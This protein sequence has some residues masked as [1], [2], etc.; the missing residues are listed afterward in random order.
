MEKKRWIVVVG[1]L[2]VQ[3]CLGA[4]YA[5]GAFTKALQDPAGPFAFS[6]TQAQAIFS[7]ALAAFAFTMIFAGRWQD[8]AGPRKV[9]L[10][11]GAVLGLGYLLAG[12]VGGTSFWAL[13]ATVGILGGIGVGLAY[14]CPIAS[15]MKW[16]PD[17][18]GFVV[19]LSVAGFGAGAF[20][21]VKLAGP[22]ANL[23]AAQGVNGT[24][25]V[26][27]IIFLA[28]V[29]LGALLLSNPP[30]GWKPANWT[31][32][33]AAASTGAAEDFTQGE[34][35]RTTSFWL[36][37]LAY[38]CAAGAGLMVIG[39][40]K[41]YGELECS[42]S[43]AVAGSALGLLALF[44]GLGRIVW[45]TISQKLGARRAIALNG[46]LQALMLFAVYQLGRS[47][48]AVTIAACWVGFNFG[49]NL[50]LFPLVTAESFGTKYLGANYGAMFTAYGVGGIIMPLLA[51]RVYDV[52]GSHFW[53]F[54][55]AGIAC[56]IAML[57]ALVVRAPHHAASRAGNPAYEAS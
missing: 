25:T 36:L 34:T 9:A 38:V 42:L 43:A 45:G 15:C 37:W 48:L 4:L 27:G 52:L 1:A 33:A 2:L 23:I 44:N 28:G 31:P 32:K 3:L 22:W 19:G 11:G 20:I 18:K 55:A 14:V 54:V 49:G 53:A 24:F 50:A 5:W 51:G 6:A 13:L 41:N 46:A 10:T 35:V 56:V 21:F 26:F 57:L 47:E 8:K 7:A 12:T 30:A 39:C 40:V 16:F 29:V 17:L